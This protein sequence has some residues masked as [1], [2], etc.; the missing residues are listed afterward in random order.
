MTSH[1]TLVCRGWGKP[2]VVSFADM[3]LCRGE[4]RLAIPGHGTFEV[5]EWITIDGASGRIYAGK[6]DVSI[7]HWQDCPEL[8]VLAEIIQVAIRGDDAPLEAAGRTWK[9]R[10][11]FATTATCITHRQQNVP[12]A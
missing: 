10:D 12:L 8:S 1:A 9:L 3:E 5:G 2:C 11:F 7:L 4:R 6:G